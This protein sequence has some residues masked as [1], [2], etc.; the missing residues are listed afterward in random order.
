MYLFPN[1]DANACAENPSRRF[2]HLPSD[3][4]LSNPRQRPYSQYHQM[5]AWLSGKPP[6]SAAVKEAEAAFTAEE[7]QALQ[8]HYKAVLAQQAGQ[9]CNLLPL[10]ARAA[11]VV[12]FWS[13]LG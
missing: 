7:L 5:F 6:K 13:Q 2:R 3:V 11:F 9:T 8:Q 1:C 4:Q 12:Q 10:H